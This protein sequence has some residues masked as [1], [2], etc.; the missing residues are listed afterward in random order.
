MVWL[1]LTRLCMLKMELIKHN[2][3]GLTLRKNRVIRRMMEQLNYKVL[4]LDRI[5]F[6]GLTK[7][8]I[9]RGRFRF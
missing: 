7:K 3:I 4:R 2:H 6:A 5:Q 1:Q 8:D 9:P